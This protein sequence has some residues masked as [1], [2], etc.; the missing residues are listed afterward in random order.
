M[1]KPRTQGINM[2]PIKKVTDPHSIN[3]I[4]IPSISQA[5][6]A[7][8][9]VVIDAVR[10]RGILSG[11]AGWSEKGSG[12]VGNRRRFRTSANSS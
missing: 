3:E 9:I 10:G 2:N 12:I 1:T 5:N 7:G 6:P 8:G 11:A 4:D